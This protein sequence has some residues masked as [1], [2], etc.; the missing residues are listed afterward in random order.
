MN[1]EAKRNLH[2]DLA[3]C[4]AATDGLDV[5]DGE[6]VV[7]THYLESDGNPNVAKFKRHEDAVFYVEARTGW[8]A[9]IRR[10]IEA[11]D[12]VRAHDRACRREMRRLEA[13]VER[14][15]KLMRYAESMYGVSF[16]FLERY[17]TAIKEA[18]RSLADILRREGGRQ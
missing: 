13:E 17:D 18:G 7:F 1:N 5:E 8:P 10:A 16:A 14:L 4:D 9:A 12:S 2:A 3:L 15:R 11:E 6:M